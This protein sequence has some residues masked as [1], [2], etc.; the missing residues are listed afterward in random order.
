MAT[1]KKTAKLKTVAGVTIA[2]KR[3]KQGAN[4]TSYSKARPSSHAFQPGESGNVGGKAHH[5]DAL[6]SRS[7]RVILANRAP[8]E[9]ADAF[10]LPHGASWSQCIAS[11]LIF[12]AVRGDLQA[13]A[14][15]RNFTETS[16]MSMDLDFSGGAMGVIPEIV[17]LESNGAGALRECDRAMVEADN[18]RPAP[19]EL[20]AE[21]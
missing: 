11:K 5:A 20:P 21:V 14:E 17:F 1:K 12:L 9:V 8:N 3:K 10:K 15:I 7:L 16:K 2:P 4:R 18:A 13:I 6:L 19:L